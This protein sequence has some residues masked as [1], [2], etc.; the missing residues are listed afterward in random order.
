[1]PPIELTGTGIILIV[2]FIFRN[3][4]VGV[5]AGVAS[6]SQLDESL[7]EASLTLGANSFTTLR[8]VI[9]P[10]LKPAIVAALIFGFVRAMTA[11]SAVIFLVSANY[12][13]ATSYIIGR[14]ENGDFGQ[15]IAY[16]SVLIVVMLV[17]ILAV[18]LAVGRSQTRRRADGGQ[19]S[20]SESIGGLAG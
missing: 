18:Q 6:M 4:P 3:M 16:S 14:V 2:S 7:D 9:L 13:M 19:V 5:R 20:S 11:L 10:L 12:D 8:K 15:A 17:A 1:M